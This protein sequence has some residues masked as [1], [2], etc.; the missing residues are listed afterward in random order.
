MLCFGRIELPTEIEPEGLREGSCK[1][2][3]LLAVLK[4]VGEGV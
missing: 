3:V 1:C 4:R 2:Q